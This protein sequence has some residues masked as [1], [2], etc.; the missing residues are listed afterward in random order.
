MFGHGYKSF[1]NPGEHPCFKSLQKG[2][3]S[4]KLRKDPQKKIFSQLKL[5]NGHDFLCRVTRVWRKARRVG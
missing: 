4:W 1:L 3:D 2:C 5:R